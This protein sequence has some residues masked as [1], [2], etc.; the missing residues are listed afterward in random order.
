VT[1]AAWLLIGIGIGTMLVVSALAYATGWLVA[2][3]GHLN[4][5]L[6]GLRNGSHNGGQWDVAEVSKRAHGDPSNM[7][8]SRG[9]PMRSLNYHR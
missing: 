2:R 1:G 9:E 4:T 7:K 3:L 5:E 6:M 8:P